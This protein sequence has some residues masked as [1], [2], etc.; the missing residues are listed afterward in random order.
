MSKIISFAIPLVIAALGV[1]TTRGA[2]VTEDVLNS[3]S[4]PNKVE[5]SIVTLE[6]LDGAPLSETAGKV[7]DYLDTMRAAD[8]FMKGMPGASLKA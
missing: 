2:Q 5:T 7:Y 8:T 1:T 6:F 4:T 3:I